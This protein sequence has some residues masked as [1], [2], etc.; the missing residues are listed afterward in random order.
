[1]LNLVIILIDKNN[2]I[3]NVGILIKP[4]DQEKNTEMFCFGVVYFY[5]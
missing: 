5:S 2:T 1:M 4:P 3:D